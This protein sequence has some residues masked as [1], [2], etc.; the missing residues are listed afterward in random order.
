MINVLSK[1]I[2]L[3]QGVEITIEVNPDDVSFEYLEA[4]SS[5]GI[6]RLSIGIQSFFDRELKLMNR[7][8]NA[9]QG[10]KTIEWTAKLFQNFSVI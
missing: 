1:K 4:L 2:N 7:I 3:S 8:H 9:D 10:I 5:I 6:N